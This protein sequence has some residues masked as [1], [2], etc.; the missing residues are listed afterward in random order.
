MKGD[1]LKTVK[2]LIVFLVIGSTALAS[3]YQALSTD[4][5]ASPMLDAKSGESIYEQLADIYAV[6]S[7]PIKA[8]LENWVSGRCYMDDAKDKAM[9]SLLVGQYLTVGGEHGPLFPPE[10]LLKLMVIHSPS[11]SA[12]DMDS[13][14]KTNRETNQVIK[15]DIDS[16]SAAEVVDDAWRSVYEAGNLTYNIRISGQ[17]YFVGKMVVNKDVGSRKAGDV[18]AYCYYFKKIQ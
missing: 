12:D 16:M 2:F 17:G 9:N 10:R 13:L 5:S 1:T 8:D 7:L 6:S 14:K 4:G 3:Q 15:R 11:K 18:Y